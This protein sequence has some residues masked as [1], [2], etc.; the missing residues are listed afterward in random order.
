MFPLFQLTYSPS[1]INLC[2]PL[3]NFDICDISFSD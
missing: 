1:V 2:F 3:I